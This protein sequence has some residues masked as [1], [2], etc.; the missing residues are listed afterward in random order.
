MYPAKCH[1][2]LRAVFREFF[3]ALTQSV[4]QDARSFDRSVD[5]FR[6]SHNATRIFTNPRR[7][8]LLVAASNSLQFH[9]EICYAIA[10]GHAMPSMPCR[11]HQL[12]PREA[13]RKRLRKGVKNPFQVPL[14]PLQFLGPDGEGIFIFYKLLVL[15]FNLALGIFKAPTLNVVPCLLLFS[16]GS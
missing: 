12:Y 14:F 15:H 8:T 3:V 13:K 16:E 9:L 4:G 1:P 5:F 7:S 2:F 6:Q 11:Y 10:L